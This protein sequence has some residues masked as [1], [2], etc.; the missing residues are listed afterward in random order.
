MSAR[1]NFIKVTLSYS[2]AMVALCLVKFSSY[3]SIDKK[4]K[5]QNY[6]SLVFW[7]SGQLIAVFP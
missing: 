2:C 3:F 7:Q 5:K 4:K 6:T 1:I